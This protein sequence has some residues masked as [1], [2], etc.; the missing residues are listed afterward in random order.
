MVSLENQRNLF[1]EDVDEH[2][3]EME[4]ALLELELRPDNA[5]RINAVFRAMHTI[6][7]AANLFGSQKITA[8]THEVET[9]FDRVRSRLLPVSKML[10]DLSLAV[11][12]TIYCLAHE[13]EDSVDSVR[14]KTLVEAFQAMSET[15]SEE[16][17]P[18]ISTM[19][20]PHDAPLASYRI[21]FKPIKRSSLFQVHPLECLRDL[22]KQGQLLIVTH[23]EDLPPL[24]ELDPCHW[25]VSFELILEKPAHE[26]AIDEIRD[27]FIFIEDQ[28]E[29]DIEEI[30]EARARD[31][32]DQAIV[33][34]TAGIGTLGETVAQKPPAQAPKAP[35]SAAPSVPRPAAKPAAPA[36]SPKSAPAET[37]PIP[38]KSAEAAKPKPRKEHSSL[39][40]DAYKLDD[41]VALVGELVIAQSRLS[42]LAFQRHDPQLQ[43]VAEEMERLSA[44]LR[45]STLS[46]R[47]LPIGSTFDRFRRLV[48]DLSQELGKEIDLVTHGAETELDKTVIEQLGDPLVHLLRN[49]IDHGIETPETREAAGKSRRGALTLSAEHSGGH[50]LI[51]IEDDGKGLDREV[52]AA[53]AVERG[54]IQDPQHLS[55]KEIF[56]CIFQPG[57]STAH[58]V[59][60]VS[61]R[62]VGMDV[63]KKSIDGLRGSVDL[64]SVTG[65]GTR[66]TVKLPLTLAIIEGLQVRV[67]DE[68][69]VI[70]LSSVE[71]C[72]E[73]V[74]DERME[75]N[76][77]RII[78]LRSEIVPYIRLRDYFGI[79]GKLPAV[80]QIIIT[81]SDTQHVGICVDEVIG[82]QQTVIKNMG[83]A[84]RQLDEFSGATIQGDGSMAL[85]LDI[86]SLVKK[87]QLAG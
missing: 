79:E 50:V 83:K 51:R 12:D 15:P 75:Q 73:L 27:A 47:M 63:V 40:V 76:G 4:S 62:G 8:L 69:F 58:Q 49:S 37:K 85:I 64:E 61:G 16:A 78:N 77:K 24:D 42:A 26:H 11:K 29:I 81:E 84:F 53:K 57:F 7:G 33:R 31:M 25:Y 71:E 2:L 48:R 28:C 30:D 59:T 67:D 86:P 34:S 87:V 38:P 35:T 1:L 44:L 39:R 72:V 45:D 18:P 70:P 22:E 41:M 9:V 13:G 68:F 6:K 10:L 3:T 21:L 56:N 20:I 14:F 17:K 43:S 32:I 74:R 60:N 36:P 46:M 5:D 55:D 82:Q 52:I 80:E 54:L 65:Q 23:L 66:I 19:R